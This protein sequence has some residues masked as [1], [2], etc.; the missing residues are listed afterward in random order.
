MPVSENIKEL[1]ACLR[2]T[3][4][5]FADRIGVKRNTVATYEMGRSVPSEAALNLICREF[6]VRREWLETGEGEMFVRRS[7]AILEQLAKEYHLDGQARRLVENFL[8]LTQENREMVIKAFENA[9]MLMTQKPD[10]ELTREEAMEKVGREWDEREA[11]RK[12]GVIT[13]SAS[14]TTSGSKERFGIKP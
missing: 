6:D 7:T 9:A 11:A 2:I 8:S 12:R 5:E 13:S 4:Q 14:T 1:R 3:Q 10:S